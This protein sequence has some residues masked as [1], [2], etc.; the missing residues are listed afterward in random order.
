MEE[1]KLGRV[2]FLLKI[3]VACLRRKTVRAQI[4]L[5]FENHPGYFQIDFYGHVEGRKRPSKSLH[6]EELPWK[7]SDDNDLP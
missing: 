4:G 7:L 1:A 2:R 5:E 3:A 6:L